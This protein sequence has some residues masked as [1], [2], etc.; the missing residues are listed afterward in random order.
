MQCM[1]TEGK[2]MASAQPA[3]RH[4]YKLY[5]SLLV[6]P[7]FLGGG[8]GSLPKDAKIITIQISVDVKE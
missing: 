6:C 8:G 4:N 3:G 1:R 2:K 5:C 7:F